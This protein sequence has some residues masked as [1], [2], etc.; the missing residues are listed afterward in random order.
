[1]RKCS[2]DPKPRVRHRATSLTRHS[3]GSDPRCSR[4][5]QRSR[6]TR[7]TGV[8]DRE[9]PRIRPSS[10]SRVDTSKSLNTNKTIPPAA[11]CGPRA[12]VSPTV[13]ARAAT[14]M[15]F[16]FD[17]KSPLR[18]PHT[19]ITAGKWQDEVERLERALDIDE[20]Y[21]LESGPRG[22]RRRCLR[23]RPRARRLRPLPSTSR[24]MQTKPPYA[25]AMWPAS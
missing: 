7:A 13:R 15:G 17:R 4:S 11:R 20:A 5:R 16:E 1:M 18:G 12:R 14:R 2:A 19:N 23:A 8:G 10:H 6:R 24:F 22:F 3:T 9:R 25:A 21:A